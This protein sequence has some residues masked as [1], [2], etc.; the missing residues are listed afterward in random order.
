[1]DRSIKLALS[2]LSESILSV[3][4]HFLADFTTPGRA[5][6]LISWANK[7]K[8]F[9]ARDKGRAAGRKG[10][11]FSIPSEVRFR[12]LF[13]VSC[14]LSMANCDSRD[15][16]QIHA[17]YNKRK[18]RKALM[19]VNRIKCASFYT[20]ARSLHAEIGQSPWEL[21]FFTVPILSMSLWRNNWENGSSSFG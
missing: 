21:S 2:D 5:T 8:P 1:M 3:F 17:N 7:N 14:K 13:P 10:K 11:S 9:Q 15:Q 4:R 16:S 18:K 20:Y 12:A 6:P 19:M